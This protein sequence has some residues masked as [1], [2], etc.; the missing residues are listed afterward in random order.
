MAR[1]HDRRVDQRRLVDNVASL[2]PARLLDEFDRT[3]DQRLHLARRDR[4]GVLGIVP[5]DESVEAFDKL[6]IADAVGGREQPGGGDDGAT[7]RL[8]VLLCALRVH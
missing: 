8:L 4:V 5:I 2:D 6:G 1:L 7:A 3:V